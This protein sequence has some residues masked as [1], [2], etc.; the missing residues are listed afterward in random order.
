[1]AKRLF[2]LD[3]G[4]TS[5]KVVELE[6]LPNQ[7]KLLAVGSM[8]TPPRWLASES[9]VDLTILSEAVKRL[10]AQAHI[11]TKFLNA[12]LAENLA[13]TRILEMPLLSEKELTSAIKWESE[14]YIPLP[15]DQV[16]LDFSILRQNTASNKMDVLL[17]GAPTSLIHKYQKILH[18]AGLEPV[19]LETEILALSRVLTPQVQGVPSTLLV[20]IGASSTN[21]AVLRDGLLVVPYSLPVG[22]AAMTRAIAAEFAFE[23][24]Q[25]EQYKRTYGIS[26][27]A[28]SG[29]IKAAVLPVVNV[30]LSEMRKA[31]SFYQNKMPADPQV[32]RIILSGGGALMPGLPRFFAE[33]LGIETDIGNPW[34]RIVV[35][36]SRFSSLLAFSPMFSVATGLALRE[37]GS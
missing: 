17:V 24:P 36:E 2:G 23:G 6:Q 33:S 7:V 30:I 35:E 1:M 32:K 10:V 9:D 15:L 18:L 19:Y 11:G 8:P 34:E 27:D 13:F 5:I 14:Q 20:D 4:T 21:L 22:A 25:A 28:L 12:S 29:K 16:T 37:Y 31:I 26:E 3:I